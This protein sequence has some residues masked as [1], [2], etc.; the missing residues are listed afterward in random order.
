MNEDLKCHSLTNRAP[1]VVIV[2]KAV[3]LVNDLNN[4]YVLVYFSK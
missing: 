3:L 2:T 1:P 4:L